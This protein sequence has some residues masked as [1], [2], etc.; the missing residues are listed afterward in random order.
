[1]STGHRRGYPAPAPR[2]RLL[3]WLALV[4]L[5]ALAAVWALD[6]RIG[7]DAPPVATTP[8]EPA[9]PKV[10]FPEGLRRED[11]AARLDEQTDLSGARYL[12]LT[13]PGRLGR[14]LSG[15]DRP[16]S[17][18]GFL[19]PATYV[20]APDTTVRDLVDMQVQAYRDNTAGVD[21]RYARSKNLTPYDVLILA[22]MI[23]R[24]VQ[25]PSERRIVAG[26]LYNRLRQR[27][28]LDIDAT[29]Q[30]AIGSWKPD[31]TASDLNVDSPYNTRR[32]AGLPPGPI[33]NPG[34][35]SIQ[36]A[37]RP[38]QVPYL[39]YVAKNDGSGGHYFATTVE[40][41]DRAVARSQAN[42]AG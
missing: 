42:A 35:S 2:R 32:Y 25:V 37:A 29:V 21:L 22:S 18:E 12:A 24:E 9:G 41:H 19:F 34:L 17:L 16:V 30:Y 4:L 23:E 11:I 13:G 6:V 39:Y 28:R 38:R 1:V 31:L 14:Q 33:S 8:V 40:Q 15:A 10:T 7:G 26:V 36:A 3:G 5:A 20:I 27:M